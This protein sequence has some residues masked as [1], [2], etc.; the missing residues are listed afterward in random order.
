[1][2]NPVNDSP[3]RGVKEMETGGHNDKL[4]DRKIIDYRIVDQDT[5]SDYVS[6]LWAVEDYWPGSDDK[7]QI[8]SWRNMFGGNFQTGEPRQVI[9]STA[10][11]YPWRQRDCG[12]R[13]VRNKQ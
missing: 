9:K 5:L 13:I 10:A 11:A 1:M 6:D 3:L 2:K 12:F 4:I 8:I 7:G